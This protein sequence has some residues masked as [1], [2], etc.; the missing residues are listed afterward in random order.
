MRRRGETSGGGGGETRLR[1]RGHRPA[2]LLRCP[3]TTRRWTCPTA[4]PRAG[5]SGRAWTAAPATAGPAS[6]EAI[7]FPA[8]STSTSVFARTDTKVR[9]RPRSWTRT[10]TPSSLDLQPPPSAGD[11]CEVL[12]YACRSSR[13]CQNGG[14][15][16]EGLCVCPPSFTGP[17]CG[18][19]QCRRPSPVPPFWSNSGPEVPSDASRPAHHYIPTTGRSAGSS[20]AQGDS[21]ASEANGTVPDRGPTRPQLHPRRLC[22]NKAFLTVF[23]GDVGPSLLLHVSVSSLPEKTA[24]RPRLRLRASLNSDVLRDLLLMSVQMFGCPPALF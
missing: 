24:P 16:V 7:A 21:E 6:T 13:Q 12:K 2:A 19:G 15:C 10:R 5:T 22:S 9:V 17:T 3:S 8:P 1:R 23:G 20:R 14:L 4:S 18:Q 11:R